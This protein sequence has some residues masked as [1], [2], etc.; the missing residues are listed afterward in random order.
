MHVA[1]PLISVQFGL[2]SF[3]GIHVQCMCSI[4]NDFTD[5]ATACNAI[6]CLYTLHGPYN[7]HSIYNEH[8]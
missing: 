6:H 2:Y 3:Q 4:D 8:V 1:W 5:P 7:V